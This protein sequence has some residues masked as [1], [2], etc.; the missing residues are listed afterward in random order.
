MNGATHYILRAQTLDGK[1][2]SETEVS[3][4]PGTV[5]HLQ[6][7]TTYS[8]NVLSVNSGGRSQPSLPKVARTGISTLR[9]GCPPLYVETLSSQLLNAL[10]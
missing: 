8:L 10:L 5:D 3:N 6:P 7:Y 2:F 4:S 9:V 1:F